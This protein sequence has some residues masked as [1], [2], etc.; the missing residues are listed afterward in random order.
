MLVLGHKFKLEVWE[1]VVKM[2][3]IGEVSSFVVKKE[4]ME[5]LSYSCN[6]VFF[7]LFI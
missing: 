3:A 2:M 4:V 7:F 5:L 1:T 6:T